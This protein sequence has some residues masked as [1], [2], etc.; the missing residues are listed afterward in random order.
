[1]DLIFCVQING[2]FFVST[3]VCFVL[4]YLW[5]LIQETGVTL[6]RNFFFLLMLPKMYKRMSESNYKESKTKP[7]TLMSLLYQST[8]EE[9]QSM[10]ARDSK[11]Q[12]NSVAREASSPENRKA[13]WLPLFFYIFGRSKIY[14][15]I[16]WSLHLLLNLYGVYSWRYQDFLGLPP[17]PAPRKCTHDQIVNGKCVSMSNRHEIRMQVAYYWG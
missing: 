5:E 15:F 16:F 12:Q 4:F 2:S 1:M 17:P 14:W 10:Q 7:L 11:Q 6:A 8:E 9:R 13:I 3:V